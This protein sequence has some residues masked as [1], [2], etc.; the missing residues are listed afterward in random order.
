MFLVGNQQHALDDKNR[1]RLPAKHREELGNNYILMPGMNGCIFVYPANEQ[2]KLLAAIKDMDSFDPER[3]EW[4]R[5]IAEF[6]ATAE[7]DSQGRF[8][9]PQDLL[10]ICGI[11][12]NV[13]IVG[14]ISK[15]EIWSEE[16]YL[17]RR[18]VQDHSPKGFDALYRNLHN[19]MELK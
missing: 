11:K 14:A 8:M 5:S 4:V 19:A 9:L 1:I 10:D 7:A 18:N 12:K 17:E 16:R 13:R 15:V 6:S 2:E 3:A